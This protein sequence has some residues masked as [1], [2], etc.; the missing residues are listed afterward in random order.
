MESITVRA[1]V[2]SDGKKAP[3]TLAPLPWA[4][5]ARTLVLAFAFAAL[6]AWGITVSVLL[7]QKSSTAP[8]ASVSPSPSTLPS[9]SS[10]PAPGLPIGSSVD[11][12]VIGGGPGGAYS[13]WRLQ[14]QPGADVHLYEQSE[15]LGG[16][17]Y[18]VPVNPDC[19]EVVA[20]LGGM[21]LRVGVDKVALRVCELLGIPLLPFWMNGEGDTP[22]DDPL[23]TMLLRGVRLLRG[24]Y[25]NLTLGDARAAL[26]YNL[27]GAMPALSNPALPLSYFTGAVADALISVVR[28]VP[29]PCAG[30]VNVAATF[31]QPL[32][33]QPMYQWSYSTLQQRLGLWRDWG[34]FAD[35]T[36]G[37]T[38]AGS[39]LAPHR[40]S[41]LPAPLSL[42]AQR[43]TSR[44]PCRLPIGPWRPSWPTSRDGLCSATYGLSG[45]CRKSRILSSPR[46]LRCA[47][48][49]SSPA[50]VCTCPAGSSV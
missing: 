50:P 6:S 3:S 29:D 36:A 22:E 13:A 10:S 37:E 4:A 46:S 39:P 8:L 14:G 42:L 11:I 1:P 35:D 45:A 32:E 31:T 33:G 2:S 23:N 30:D 40:V 48:T 18:S 20:E 41:R 38:G 49:Q 34:L 26:E 16:R 17:T 24:A 5:W 19:P 9:P 44:A 43:T 15:R 7:A 28:P 21:R 27:Q 47:Q 25:A 12:A